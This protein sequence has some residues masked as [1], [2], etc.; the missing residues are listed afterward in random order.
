[1]KLRIGI[2][3]KGIKKRREIMDMVGGYMNEIGLDAEISHIGE[4]PFIMQDILRKSVLYD[5]III[6]LKDEVKFISTKSPIFPEDHKTVIIKTAQYPLTRET[7]EGM[8]DL[9]FRDASTGCPKGHYGINR[10][11]SGGIRGTQ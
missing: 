7:I 5:I 3:L 1:M 10:Q 9:M 11:E 6:C 4:F 8:L 2:Y